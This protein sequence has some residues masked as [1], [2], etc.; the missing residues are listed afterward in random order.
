MCMSLYVH[1]EAEDQ[2]QLSS[3]L[4]FIFCKHVII[5]ILCTH[6]SASIYVYTLRVCLMP[7]EA[8]REHH[9]PRIGIMYVWW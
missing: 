6:M 1:V 4:I 8:R 7:M 2:H 9:I 3:E 5:F